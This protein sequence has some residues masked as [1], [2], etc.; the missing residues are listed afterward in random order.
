MS[1]ESSSK[2]SSYLS[3][4]CAPHGLEI[5][6]GERAPAEQGERLRLVHRFCFWIFK[7]LGGNKFQPRGVSPLPTILPDRNPCRTGVML[8]WIQELDRVSSSWRDS[9]T[10]P[11]LAR[12][13]VVP[14]HWFQARRLVRV[15]VHQQADKHFPHLLLQYVSPINHN[16]WQAHDHCE[17]NLESHAKSKL[18]CLRKVLQSQAEIPQCF[19]LLWEAPRDW[20]TSCCNITLL[21][22]HPS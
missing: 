22:Y 19:P 20:G 17:R 5:F 2:G 10:S 7:N 6:A 16:R 1:V 15:A 11:R 18:F 21:P 4:C 8:L 14:P 13:T 3:C 12:S 9:E